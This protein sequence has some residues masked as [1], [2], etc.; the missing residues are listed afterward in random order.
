M[1]TSFALLNLGGGE[2][3]LILTLILL[4]FGGKRLPE[5]A[6]RLGSGI[7]EFKATGEA[8]DELREQDAGLD[9]WTRNEIFLIVTLTCLT[10]IEVLAVGNWLLQ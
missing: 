1:N 2:I 6:K 3:I 9:I 5:L 7:K 4:L 8:T 10:V